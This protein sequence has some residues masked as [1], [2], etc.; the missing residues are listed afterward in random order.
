MLTLLD[1]FLPLA[2][3]LLFASSVADLSQPGAD[4]A[5]GAREVYVSPTGDDAS[6][7]TLAHPW[8]TIQHAADHALAGQ[9]VNV[10]GGVYREAVTIRVSGTAQAGF[11]TFRSYPGERAV[12]DGT[13]LVPPPDRE[14]GLIS[15]A[16]QSYVAIEGLDVRRYSAAS[17]NRVPAGIQVTGAG[18]HIDLRG[19]HVHDI[20][21]TAKGPLCSRTGAG[22]ANA[23]GIVVYGSRAP[24]ALTDVR[25]DHNELDHLK[26]GCSESLALNG[27][28]THWRVENNLVHDTDNIGIDAIGFE[29]VA[30]DAVY[31]Q[32]R[33]G[34]I[35]QNLVYNV[36]SETNA[37][38]PKG[39]LSADGIYVDGGA[40][41][42]VE[43]NEVHD[44]DIGIELASETRGRSTS[45]MIARNNVVYHNHA[46]GI[47]MGG[48]EFQAGGADHIA[49]LNNTLV[50][51][52]TRMTGAGELQLQHHVTRAV[53]K[54]NLVYAGSQSLLLHSMET[55]PASVIVDRNLYF[56]AGEGR[57]GRWQEKATSFESLGAYQAAT[58]QDPHSAYAAPMLRDIASA[59]FEL[60]PGSPATR[61]GDVS[62]ESL[63]GEK[64]FDGCDR[65]R[66]R[67][68]DIG[69][70]AQTDSV[71]P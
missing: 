31:D 39:D 67:A 6:A 58:R 71:R 61:A 14:A 27:N 57:T 70:L 65:V 60:M 38:Y 55:L 44:S 40:R 11:I 4:L 36:S 41:I 33:D 13:G 2:G 1:L 62:L 24:K 42:V 20:S 50:D 35:A 59:H 12:V 54:N 28:V 56:A 22:T 51:N 52:D 32:A 18:E 37:S 3:T 30:P 7:G 8:R 43:R 17:T 15:I 48:Y 45:E 10:R 47:S 25:I 21:I 68:I 64:D 63:V 19:N 26:T 66:D 34:V 23:F 29:G 5:N 69:A 16:D 49:V 46:A 9:T 53:L